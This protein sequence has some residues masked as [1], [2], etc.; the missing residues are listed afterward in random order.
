MSSSAPLTRYKEVQHY[1]YEHNKG[2]QRVLTNSGFPSFITA[3]SLKDYHLCSQSESYTIV[4]K[5]N[6]QL[7]LQFKVMNDKVANETTEKLLIH[8]P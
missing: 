3:P 8:K 2:E 6:D 1:Y 7:N 5:K 4:T